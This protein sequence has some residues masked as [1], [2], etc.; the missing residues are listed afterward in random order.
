MLDV[1]ISLTIRG[2]GK[3]RSATSAKENEVEGMFV[4]FDGDPGPAFLDW[5][6]FR[7]MVQYKG[8]MQAQAN[9]SAHRKGAADA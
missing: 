2:I 6:S 5:A 1:D 9:G 7:R 4:L 3:G 8:A